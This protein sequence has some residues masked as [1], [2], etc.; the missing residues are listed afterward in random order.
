MRGGGAV[1]GV[2]FV[3]LTLAS[4]LE[5]ASPRCKMREARRGTVT[6]VRGYASLE[7]L[8]RHSRQ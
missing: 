2:C 4:V 6:G 1:T 3:Q 7:I 8:R 5:G